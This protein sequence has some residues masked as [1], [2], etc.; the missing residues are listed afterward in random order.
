MP[1]P[2]S[3]ELRTAAD[4]LLDLVRKNKKISVEEAAK[5]LRMPVSS[6]QALVDFLVE[7]RIFGIEYK[8]TT[9]YIYLYKE[10]VQR[11]SPKEKSFTQGLLTKEQFYEKAK[12][13]NMPH[14]HIGVLWRKYIQ[15]NHAQIREEFL[16]NAK[17]KNIPQEKIEELWKK[18]LSYL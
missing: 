2:D 12:E 17:E 6:V 13:R 16:I 4:E 3:K 10:G 8:F 1:P 7:E 18:Y 9:P 14:E 5:Q 11:A 15:Q